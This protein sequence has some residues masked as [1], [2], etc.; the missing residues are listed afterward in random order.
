MLGSAHATD[1]ISTFRGGWLFM[2]IASL[3]GAALAAAM[4]PVRQHAGVAAAPAQVALSQS[5]AS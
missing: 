1:L 4:G 3:L 5:P 2:V